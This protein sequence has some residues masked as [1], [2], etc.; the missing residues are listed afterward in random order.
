MLRW[1][2][3]V[4]FAALI[5]CGG[6]ESAA[7]AGAAPDAGAATAEVAAAT[8]PIPDEMLDRTWVVGM[9]TQ[10]AFQPYADKA[11]WVTLV[12]K[13]D[14]ER[15]ASMLD[16]DPGGLA[17]ARVHAEIVGYGLSGDAYHI[18][19]P[20]EDGEGAIRAMRAALEDGG[21]EPTHVDYINAHGTSTPAG[22]R[23][24]TL[25]V[26]RLFGQ[27]AGELAFASTKSM[28]GHLLGAAGGLETAVAALALREGR[29]PRS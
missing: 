20:S 10:E 29:L 6:G 28:T 19:A 5:G 8:S 16:T 7:P 26:K 22:D 12:V 18:S 2:M 15:A 11:G 1:V 17:G 27:Q 9:A 3:P 21:I 24:E 4:A 13:R 25:A 14:Y 23:I